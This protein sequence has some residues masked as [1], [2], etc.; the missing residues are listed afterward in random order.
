MGHYWFSSSVHERLFR[1]GGNGAERRHSVGFPREP[2]K[3][4]KCLDGVSGSTAGAATA[5]GVLVAHLNM[6]GVVF[7][8]HRPRTMIIF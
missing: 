6:S 3:L 5:D 4:G 7:S 2:G 1:S 8:A